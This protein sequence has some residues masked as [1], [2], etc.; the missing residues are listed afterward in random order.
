MMAKI[1]LDYKYDERKIIILE[2]KELFSQTAK[3]WAKKIGRTKKTQARNFYD[4]ILE[5]E[6]KTKNES[7]ESVY[8][9]V[10]MLNSKVAYAANR[11]VVSLEFQ[12]MMQQALEQIKLNSEGEQKFKNFKLFF[13]AVLG[14]FKGSN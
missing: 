14:F 6:K 5:L 3:E 7:W 11:R 4:K 13:E 1:N 10:K 12:E 2:D 8:P 9:F